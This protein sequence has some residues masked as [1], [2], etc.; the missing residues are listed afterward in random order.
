MPRDL[1]SMMRFSILVAH[2]QAVTAADAVGLEEEFDGVGVFF[3][4]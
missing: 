2:A 4:V 1:A 3:A